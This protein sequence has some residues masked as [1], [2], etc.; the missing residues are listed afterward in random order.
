MKFV[1][2]TSE[3]AF[4]IKF[5]WF[6]NDPKDAAM[7]AA[8]RAA[9]LSDSEI[10][11]SPI[12]ILQDHFRPAPNCCFQAG[13]LILV[14]SNGTVFIE[15]A[16]PSDGIYGY[17]V[18]KYDP[19]F[20]DATGAYTRDEWISA[21][22]VGSAFDGVLLTR[23]EYLRVESAY[24]DA[25]LSFLR[26]AGVDSLT[27]NGLENSARHELPFGEGGVLSI[28][29][30]AD[31]MRRVLHDEF[32]CRLVAPLAYVHFGWDYYMYVGVPKRVPK[33]EAVARELGLFAEPFRSPYAE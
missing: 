16:N 1:S 10:D 11:E 22:D 29:A 6:S 18:T 24:V 30:S 12:G 4:G 21:S 20:R 25:A 13:S 31:V 9:G 17:R 19:Q 23:E 3:E 5:R 7:V 15:C 27:V 2:L 33:S 8:A 32:W 14:G 28:D 26:E